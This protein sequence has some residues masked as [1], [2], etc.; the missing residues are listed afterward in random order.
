MSSSRGHVVAFPAFSVPPTGKAPVGSNQ[1][2][3]Q[4]EAS[5]VTLDIKRRLLV[6]FSQC[7]RILHTEL[8]LQLLYVQT[9]RQPDCFYSSQSANS[10]R[11]GQ[12]QEEEVDKRF[13][14]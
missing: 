12:S 2:P 14:D 13:T 7:E 9:L 3:S 5:I 11:T 4:S 8:D 1:C 10:Q 6:S